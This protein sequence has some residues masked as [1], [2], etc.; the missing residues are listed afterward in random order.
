[1][2]VN[3][4]KIVGYITGTFDCL[5]A[6]HHRLLK[7]CK[8]QCDVLMVGLVTDQLGEKQKRVPIFTYEE[9]RAALEATK[10]VDMVVEHNG[11]TKPEA[12]QKLGFDVLFSGDE[13]MK[14]NEFKEFHEAYPNKKVVYFPRNNQTST[15]KIWKRI[16]AR[17]KAEDEKVLAIG[18]GGLIMQ[19]GDVV[20]KHCNVSAAEMKAYSETNDISSDVLGFMSVKDGKLPRNWRIKQT[21]S[22]ELFPMIAGINVFRELVVGQ[23]FLTSSWN[24]YI[25]N[26]VIFYDK[27]KVEKECQPFPGIQDDLLEFAQWVET[28]R[29][30]PTAIVAITQKHGGIT[31]KKYLNGFTDSKILSAKLKDVLTTVRHICNELKTATVVHGDLHAENI[32]IDATSG[33]K[34]S[35][36]DFGWSSCLKFNLC[37]VEKKITT[38]A[39]ENDWDYAHF[40]SS[41]KLDF[42]PCIINLVL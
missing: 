40:I 36:I 21:E 7:S 15:S 13:Y 4:K 16:Q 39:L 20:V 9:R 31:L 32:L 35:I 17:V 42:G 41:L 12:F 2:S 24:T 6:S 23:M 19:K 38:E 14:S 11:E 28:E 22:S 37:D 1:M 18:V 29:R 5:H 34:V 26:K 10:W 27:K 3:T 8:Q 30:F 33:I 25:T